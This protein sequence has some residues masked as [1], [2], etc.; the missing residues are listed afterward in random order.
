METN[1]ALFCTDPEAGT[2]KLTTA[3]APVGDMY[4]TVEGQTG[5]PYE[6]NTAT[7]QF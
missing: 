6:A 2:W 5:N 3:A 4:Y 7:G 1:G